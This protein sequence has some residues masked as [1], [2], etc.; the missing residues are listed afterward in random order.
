MHLVYVG[1][2]F[3]LGLSAGIGSIAMAWRAWGKEARGFERVAN[4]ALLFMT[5][6]TIVVAAECYCYLFP[7]TDGFGFTKSNQ[8]WNQRHWGDVNELGYRDAPFNSAA[9][10]GDHLIVALGDSFTAG[11]GVEIVADRFSNVLEEELGQ[12]WRVA[13]VAKPAWDT[14]DELVALKEL[15]VQPRLVILAYFPNDIKH[16]V[17]SSGGAMVEKIQ[18]PPRM[19]APLVDHSYAASYWYWRLFR[20][21]Q[22]RITQHAFAQRLSVHYENEALWEVHKAKLL[23]LIAYTDMHN[24][25]LLV[26]YL[27]QVLLMNENAPIAD[28]VLSVVAKAGADVFDLTPVFQDRDPASLV[29]NPFDAHYNRD[30][31]REVGTILANV[32]AERKLLAS[33]DASETE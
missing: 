19:L 7:Q 20:V 18:P 23:E 5:L 12:P 6:F 29:V 14:A 24:I 16:A 15:P 31:H 9:A 32:I 10:D 3:V 27:P 13:N 33:R 28:K 26:V 17:V 22:P 25:E 2:V 30:T 8:L 4:M 11:S 21:L 1:I